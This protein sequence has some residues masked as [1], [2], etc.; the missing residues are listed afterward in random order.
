DIHTRGALR[1]PHHSDSP[2]PD[3]SNHG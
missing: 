1:N 2:N 3:H